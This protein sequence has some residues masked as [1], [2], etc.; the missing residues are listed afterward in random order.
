M[1]S[2]AHL[3]R[4]REL[5]DAVDARSGALTAGLTPAQRLWRPA[6]ERWGIADCFEHLVAT[7]RAYYPRVGAAI[8]AAT[9]AADRGRW[10]ATDFRPT[11]FGGWF[12][13]SAGPGGRPIRTRGPFVPPAAT[14][15]APERFLAQQATLRA[16]LHD[17]EGHDL[18]AIRIHSPLS[19]LLTLRLGECL[20][21]L[22]VHEMRHL[23]QAERVL[24]EP[25][26]PAVGA[27]SA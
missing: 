18:R 3:A 10:A 7:G 27:P 14:A 11:W 22:V 6:P 9:P 23:D 15:D 20:E 13:R 5:T 21:M 25:G 1:N 24:D 12:V 8:A 2:A 16:L 17:A 26:F 19:R 4:L